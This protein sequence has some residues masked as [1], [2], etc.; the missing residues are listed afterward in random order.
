MPSKCDF[1]L[2]ELFLN[3]RRST[4]KVQHRNLDGT[5]VTQTVESFLTY[6]NTNCII[7]F[8][9]E[10][11]PHNHNSVSNKNAHFKHKFHSWMLQAGINSFKLKMTTDFHFAIS[12]DRFLSSLL[13][14]GNLVI[15]RHGLRS[16]GCFKSGISHTLGHIG[17]CLSSFW[18]LIGVIV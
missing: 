2:Q 9:E 14:H 17:S 5:V 11:R 1:S 15:F 8:Q 13:N 12:L 18:P 4:F 6:K 10:Y 16:P 7:Q 3:L